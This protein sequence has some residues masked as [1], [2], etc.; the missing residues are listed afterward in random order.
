MLEKARP[1]AVTHEQQ[2]GT[3]GQED[4]RRAS[5]RPR[6]EATRGLCL[7]GGREKGGAAMP[8]SA[9]APQP[10]PSPAHAEPPRAGYPVHTARAGHVDQL[11]PGLRLLPTSSSLTAAA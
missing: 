11:Q 2:A 3:G 1:V 8:W 10:C 6:P 4:G 7:R 5:L 9:P